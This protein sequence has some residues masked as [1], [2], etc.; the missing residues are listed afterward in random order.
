M[1]DY[2]NIQ[3]ALNHIDPQ[4]RETWFRMGAAIKDELGENGFEMWDNWSRQSDNYKQ[5]D[6]QSVWKSIKVGHIH[7]ASL[8]KTA[9]EKCRG[10]SQTLP[11]RPRKATSRS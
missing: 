5:Q 7:I 9:R 2:D 4:D 1:S 6:A 3:N 8:F 10:I 11:N